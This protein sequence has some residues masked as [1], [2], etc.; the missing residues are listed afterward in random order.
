MAAL[1]LMET[2]SISACLNATYQQLV[3][4]ATWLLQMACNDN[5]S[6]G[7][8]LKAD[9]KRR[10][11]QGNRPKIRDT[12]VEGGGWEWREAYTET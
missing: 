7:C 4:D 1:R 11:K 5:S 10:P 12:M 2:V 9:E 6:V 3:M 8:A